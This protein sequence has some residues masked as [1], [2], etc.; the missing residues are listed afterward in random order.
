M[1]IEKAANLEKLQTVDELWEKAT[2]ALAREGLPHAIYLTVDENYENV[3]LR[4]TTEGLYS[5]ARSANGPFI[6][7]YCLSYEIRRIGIEFLPADANISEGE[8]DLLEWIATEKNFRS[9]LAIPMRVRGSQRFGGFVVG[10]G[11]NKSEFSEHFLPRS[12]EIRAFCLLLHRRIEELTEQ[13]STTD[14]PRGLPD[15]AELSETFSSLTPR[16]RE[17]VFLLAQGTSRQQ[18]AEICGI[19]VHTVSDYAKSGYRKLGVHNR[20]EAA[21]LI[22]QHQISPYLGD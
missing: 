14:S 17:V 20:A 9:G 7:Q 3:F 18:A 6:R 4:T 10:C 12:E 5:S 22:A 15:A 1:L 11:M 8:R 16:E 2:D 21:A 19:S 13:V